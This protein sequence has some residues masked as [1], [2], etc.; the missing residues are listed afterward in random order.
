MEALRQLRRLRSIVT[1]NGR[2]AIHSAA[3]MRTV[4]AVTRSVER[5]QRRDLCTRG[6]VVV[7]CKAIRKSSVRRE[8]RLRFVYWRHNLLRVRVVTGGGRAALARYPLV[9]VISFFGW[10]G[11]AESWLV[12]RRRALVAGRCGRAAECRGVDLV[13]LLQPHSAVVAGHVASAS[14]V[15]LRVRHR[16]SVVFRRIDCTCAPLHDGDPSSVYQRVSPALRPSV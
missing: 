1:S 5:W 14:S 11:D 13:F 10:A 12:S 8:V 4:C 15:G 6:R 3:M 9:V 16:K 2:M 7:L